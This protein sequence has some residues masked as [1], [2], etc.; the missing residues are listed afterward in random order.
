[1]S[2]IKI[3]QLSSAI[4]NILDEY[5]DEVGKENKKAVDKAAKDCD[6]AIRQHISFKQHSGKYVKAFR[7]KT[8]HE[9]KHNKTRTWFVTDGQYRLSHL[10]ENG[11]Q[12]RQG[13]R[14]K[15]YPHIK[16]G[17]EIAQENLPKYIE[18]GLK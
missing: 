4:E 10:L 18:E 6:R 16:Y 3:D 11:H 8:T 9:T 14:A 5:T 7:V 12:L 15:A 2:S 17:E 1:M 13:G